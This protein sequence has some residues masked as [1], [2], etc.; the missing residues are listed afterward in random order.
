[1]TMYHGNNRRPSDSWAQKLDDLID[2][3]PLLGTIMIGLAIIGVMV[4]FC[5]LSLCFLAK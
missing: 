1:M 2:E 3:S 4:F 5:T